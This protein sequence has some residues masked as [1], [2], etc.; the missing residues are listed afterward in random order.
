MPPEALISA[1]ARSVFT[2]ISAPST[3]VMGALSSRTPILMGEPVAWPELLPL[4]L[5]P[6]AA[7]SSTPASPAARLQRLRRLDVPFRARHASPLHVDPTLI[8]PPSFLPSLVLRVIGAPQRGVHRHLVR[9][10]SRLGLERLDAPAQPPPQGPE[11]VDG[12][13]DARGH[14]VHDDQERHADVQLRLRALL[15]EVL[16]EVPQRRRPQQRPHDGVHP[17]DQ[18]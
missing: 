3:A 8:S 10:G 13:D 1:T 2:R 7:A 5:P 9:D 12:A 11:A 4:L 18:R 6:Q 17:A 15:A 14:Q 16:A